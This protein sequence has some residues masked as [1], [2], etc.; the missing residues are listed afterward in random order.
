MYIFE[1]Y[2]LL[3]AALSVFILSL[4]FTII[5]SLLRPKDKRGTITISSIFQ[6]V[7]SDVPSLLAFLLTSV[8]LL[9]ISIDKTVPV[10]LQD[11]FFLAL[12][13]YFGS[14]TKKE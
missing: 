1:K 14:K 10:I 8:V 13:Y 4:I 7:I 11:G 9:L 2:I 6:K 12:G 5:L 3:W